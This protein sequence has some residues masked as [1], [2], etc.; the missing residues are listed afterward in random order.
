[1]RRSPP[2]LDTIL[3]LADDNDGA[4]LREA[5]KAANPALDVRVMTT[6]AGLDHL[7]DH[8]VR[9][10]RLIAFLFPDIVSSKLL[11]ALGFG[12]Y[13]IHPGPP[14]YPGW[15]PVAFAVY[16]QAQSF[17]ATL[18]HMEARPDT[19]AIV[20]AENFAIAP[21]ISHAD[22]AA[23]AFA[24]SL[25]LFWRNATLLAGSAPLPMNPHHH[26]TGTPTRRR[27]VA[28]MC[29][30]TPGMSSDEISRRHLAFGDGDGFSRFVGPSSA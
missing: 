16:Q 7:D 2:S 26:W 11:N 12:A 27:D 14:H 13:N 28:Q 5:L 30:Q 4:V 6:L 23:L 18:H 9:Q 19:G 1:M 15:A 24:A 3:L 25:R 17:G 29:A 21:G 8:Q 10:S 22:L 20:D